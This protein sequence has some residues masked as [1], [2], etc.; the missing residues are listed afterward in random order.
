MNKII[1]KQKNK[2]A[3][4]L[5]V[6]GGMV[7]AS[8]YRSY[9]S[10]L[11]NN[12]ANYALGFCSHRRPAT[13]SEAFTPVVP[14]NIGHDP[15]SSNT[16]PGITRNT[17]QIR[18]SD[19][20]QNGDGSSLP[21]SSGDTTTA[22]SPQ[23]ETDATLTV[24]HAVSGRTLLEFDH[25]LLYSQVIAQIRKELG[26]GLIIKLTQNG[27][28][29][30]SN[31]TPALGGEIDCTVQ[32][33]ITSVTTSSLEELHSKLQGLIHGDFFN[34]SLPRVDQ[35]FCHINATR[36]VESAP[37][38]EEVDE[39]VDED[40]HL[41][42]T[43]AL[44]SDVITILKDE[45]VHL[46]ESEA[47]QSDVITILKVLCDNIDSNDKSITTLRRYL[48]ETPTSLLVQFW[49]STRSPNII[50]SVIETPRHFDEEMGLDT[51]ERFQVFLDKDGNFVLQSDTDGPDKWAE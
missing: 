8:S 16:Q 31:T 48:A 11:Y 6:L 44:Q 35:Q 20:G 2:I 51:Y 43:E 39:E 22:Q 40:G 37:W 32:G 24:R 21:G 7:R 13:I 49:L 34:L 4:A 15:G 36:V 47:L 29:I 42:E 46:L 23:V 5:L 50:Q 19:T 10:G 28:V 27:Q 14:S 12:L 30:E 26:Q 1:Y 25:N 9:V 38:V 17:S 3:L 45:D 33:L 41:L 18:A